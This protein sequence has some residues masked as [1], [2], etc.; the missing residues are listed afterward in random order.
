MNLTKNEKIKRKKKYIVNETKSCVNEI[1]FFHLLTEKHKHFGKAPETNVIPVC[2]NNKKL[3][4]FNCEE[5][6]CRSWDHFGH[7]LLYDCDIYM[8]D[9]YF[10]FTLLYFTF[11][12]C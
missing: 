2:T 5:N 8:C 7:K 11:Y 1:L 9:I 10:A 12:V 6:G 3:G 4:K